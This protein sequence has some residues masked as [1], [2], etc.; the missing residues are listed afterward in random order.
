M[1]ALLLYFVYIFGK[2]GGEKCEEE[3]I[4]AEIDVFT[5]A[6]NIKYYDVTTIILNRC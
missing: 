5:E 1:F 3:K 6:T 4:I 2:N